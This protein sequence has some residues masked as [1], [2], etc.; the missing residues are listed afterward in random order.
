MPA[1]PSYLRDLS[2]PGGIEGERFL[3]TISRGKLGTCVR[4][5]EFL[6]VFQAE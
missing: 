6:H 1:V 4:E 5:A 3:E 2:M